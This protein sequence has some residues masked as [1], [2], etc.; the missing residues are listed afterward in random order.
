MLYCSAR[1]RNRV[2]NGV[3]INTSF[4][5]E[6][7]EFADVM[8][9]YSLS[10]SFNWESENVENR[11]DFTMNQPD[12][13]DD[14]AENTLV[15]DDNKV[16]DNETYN[17]YEDYLQ[18]SQDVN[19]NTDSYPDVNEMNSEVQINDETS[20][21]DKDEWNT[22]NSESENLTSNDEPVKEDNSV[23]ENTETPNLE[24]SDTQEQDKQPE[25][26]ALEIKTVLNGDE[27][28]W[29]SNQESVK[30]G[31]STQNKE[32]PTFSLE[33]ILNTDWQ[34]N[35]QNS[36]VINTES[37]ENTVSNPSNLFANKKMIGIVAWVAI[38]ALLWAVAYLAFPKWSTQKPSDTI[39]AWIQAADTGVHWTATEEPEMEFPD[40][41]A[42][43]STENW[44]L[45]WGDVD[46][47]REDPDIDSGKYWGST[48]VDIEDE[49]WYVE[50]EDYTRDEDGE[51][52]WN[53]TLVCLLIHSIILK[54]LSN[55]LRIWLIILRNIIMDNIQMMRPKH[56]LL[57]RS[58]RIFS[59][60]NR[61]ILLIFSHALH[62]SI[63]PIISSLWLR[64]LWMNT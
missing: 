64:E 58:I 9:S 34:Q 37:S 5:D 48:V 3:S 23:N 59:K 53:P 32:S 28:T 11:V 31:D 35:Q 8:P 47:D 38:F 25:E 17:H 45:I 61:G 4:V 44:G 63:Q 40:V 51:D 29:N 22:N 27:T 16:E 26:S 57:I 13:V 36:S 21:E 43:N 60:I 54:V 19:Q 10:D 42:D 20:L 2:K 55:W 24:V 56:I 6:Q 12:S 15:E 1:K 49:D 41:D 33:Q 7:S 18:E 62:L 14:T 50:D 52:T 46:G 39:V 30:D